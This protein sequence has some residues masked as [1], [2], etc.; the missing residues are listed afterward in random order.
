MGKL[1]LEARKQVEQAQERGR[2]ITEYAEQKLEEAWGN[3]LPL[4][5]EGIHMI[6]DL[7]AIDDDDLALVEAARSEAMNIAGQ[8]KNHVP[9]NEPFEIIDP[10]AGH[11]I[12]DFSEG[13]DLLF[14]EIAEDCGQPDPA[15]QAEIDRLIEMLEGIW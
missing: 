13:N 14:Q 10:P 3:T 7:E 4:G 1:K 6:E 2:E 12:T 8:I 9:Q 5:Y 11:S 15:L